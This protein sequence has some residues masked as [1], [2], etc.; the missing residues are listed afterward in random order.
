VRDFG[1]G[2]CA[3]RILTLYARLLDQQSEGE[4]ADPGPWD[5]L[6]GR[7]EIEWNLIREKTSAL[8]AAVIE[9]DATRSQLD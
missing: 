4:P 7:L 6:L 2:V 8:A 3:D 1:V 9:T 5:R